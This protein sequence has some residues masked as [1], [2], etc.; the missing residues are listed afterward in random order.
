MIA[1]CNVC[2]HEIAVGPDGIAKCDGLYDGVMWHGKLTFKY[3]KEEKRLVNITKPKVKKNLDVDPE[4]WQD[5]EDGK[6][7]SW[8]DD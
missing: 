2:Q 7:T 5:Y 3:D 1:K 6:K 8:E 4:D